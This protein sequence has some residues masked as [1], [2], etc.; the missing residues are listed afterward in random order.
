MMPH[1]SIPFEGKDLSVEGQNRSKD[2]RPSDTRLGF[3]GELHRNG[4]RERSKLAQ[5]CSKRSN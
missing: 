5:T 3:D 4:R 1:F 2:Q